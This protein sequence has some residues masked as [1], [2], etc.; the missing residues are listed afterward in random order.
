MNI[1]I[2][3]SYHKPWGLLK[4]DI[5]TPIHC[6]RALS[7]KT[8]KDGNIKSADYQWLLD[9]MLGDDTGDNISARN[10]E[11]CELTSIYWVWKNY[12]KL[13][14]PDYIGFMSYRR[15]F[16][17]NEVQYDLYSQNLEEKAYREITEESIDDIFCHKYGINLDVIAKYLNKNDVILPKR[18]ELKLI[19]IENSRDDYMRI[20]PGVNIKD[21][22]SMINMVLKLYPDFSN[23]IKEQERSS[24][25][26]FYQM[27]VTKK[28]IF[29][30]YC[31]F[32]FSV[33]TELD[34]IVDVSDYSING[35][36]TLGYLGEALFDCY[37]RKLS[38]S[39]CVKIKELGIVRTLKPY[40]QKKKIG[41][42]T[43]ILFAMKNCNDFFIIYIFG[44]K[45]SIRKKLYE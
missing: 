35:K 44:I 1:K 23:S 37:M 41:N 7:L 45:I 9:N 17:F 6:G 12:D 5:L 18:S 38:D 32:L 20:I 42:F 40:S 15:A 33:L 43:F 21:Y 13:G 16:V 29:F 8:C 10:R 36:R 25:R 26:Y 28:A 2:L 24:R 22:D 19:G 39:D 30:D 3:V 4:D 11:F 34:K 27:F 14:N 31:N